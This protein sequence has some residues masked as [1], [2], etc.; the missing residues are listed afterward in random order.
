MTQRFFFVGLF[1]VVLAAACTLAPRDTGKG[2]MFVLPPVK[3]TAHTPMGN[4]LT[5]NMPTTS[6]QLDTYRIALIRD[7]KSWDYYAH[8]RWSEFLPS[9]VQDS[10]TKTLKDAKLF[11]TVAT[12]ES[13]ISGDLILKT[14]IEGFHA[15]Y[16]GEN[17][18]P[19]IK[20]R[21]IVSLIDR[22]SRGLL[23][24]FD[25]KAQQKASGKSLS[26]IQ[27]AFAD[28]FGDAQRNLVSRLHQNPQ[29][30]G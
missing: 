16:D 20:I 30:Q 4:T 3:T 12:D 13:G 27:A 22:H 15:E 1:L 2:F 26:D 10:L 24:S 17:E 29:K 5:V 6:P 7:K 18:P 8:A 25:I 23:F 11:K 14:E 19:M 28:A 9:V 21:M